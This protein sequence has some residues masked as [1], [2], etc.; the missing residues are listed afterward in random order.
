MYKNSEL[1]KQQQLG[2]RVYVTRDEDL[3]TLMVPELGIA[4]R[5]Q[6]LNEGFKELTAAQEKYFKGAA[7]SEGDLFIPE[8]D[9]Y[10][11]AG[12]S[13][14]DQGNNVSILLSFFMKAAILLFLL[15]GIGGIGTV[16]AGNI[17][18]KNF[19]RAVS[20][21]E[22]KLED[23]PNEIKDFESVETDVSTDWEKG[24]SLWLKDL[25]NNKDSNL[26]DIVGPKLDRVLIKT[27]LEKTNGRKN[28]AA[29]LLGWGRNTLSKKIKEL[30]L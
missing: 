23:L 28:D 24:F 18:I 14:K 19:S 12:T 8:P 25:S 17:I 11:E 13:D 1:K 16:V 26:L 20:M 3:F 10:T 27:A 6:D 7:D 30:G 22:H 29:I 21:I 2:Y 9:I 4:R 15:C 5:H